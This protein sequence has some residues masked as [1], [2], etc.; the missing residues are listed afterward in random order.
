MLQACKLIIVRRKREM[1]KPPNPKPTSFEAWLDEIATAY[2]DAY[3]TLPFGELVGQPMTEADLFHLSPAVC[4]KFRGIKESKSNLKR[5]TDAALSSYAATREI[6]GDMLDVPQMAFAFCYVASHL[7]M[8]LVDEEE[9]SQILDYVE[10]NLKHLVE[11]T[12]TK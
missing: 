9:A 10:H 7:G 6:V 3:G 8:D 5:A 12:E 11:M 4:L 1:K 2:R